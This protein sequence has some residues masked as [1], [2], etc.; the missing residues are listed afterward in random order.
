M[1]SKNKAGRNTKTAATKDIKQKR[2]EK[3]AKKEAGGNQH[4]AS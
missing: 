1:A 2:L 3:K 4:L